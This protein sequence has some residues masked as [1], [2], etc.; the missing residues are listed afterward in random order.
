M[1]RIRRDGQWSESNASPVCSVAVLGALAIAM[2]EARA[3]VEHVPVSNQVYEFL[4]RL[5][6]RGVLPLASVSALP[7]SRRE[8]AEQ[9]RSVADRDSLLSPAE[10]EF[11]RKFQREFAHE[12]GDVPDDAFALIGAHESFADLAAGAV[13][14]REKYVIALTDS[15]ITLRGEFLGA[16]EYRPVWG[17]T[18]GDTHIALGSIGGRFRGT[19]VDR[20]GYFLQATNGQIWG[21]REFALSDPVLAGNV[22][23]NELNSPYFDLTQAYLRLELGYF[24]LQFGKE[25]RTMGLGYSDRLILSGNCP[26]VRFYRFRHALQVVPLHLL[27]RDAGSGLHL[28]SRT[29]RGST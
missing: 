20:L 13:S 2:P 5:G 11:L 27:P 26:G 9:L 15:N 19:V 21:D 24:W 28:L 25:I 3:Q 14:D 17:D 1:R 16:Y 18:Y 7:L 29:S 6:V 12:L 23:F 22:K 8:V 4:D 10:R